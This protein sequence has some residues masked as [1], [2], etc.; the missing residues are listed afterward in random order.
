MIRD[1]VLRNVNAECRQLNKK[2]THYDT[3][4]AEMQSYSYPDTSF[5]TKCN[6]QVVL[7]ITAVLELA[8][9]PLPPSLPHPY[10]IYMLLVRA[11]RMKIPNIPK[12]AFRIKRI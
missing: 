2:Y 8:I 1:T 6:A 5:F 7:Y 3:V 11:R 9:Q 10:A 12:L 4:S